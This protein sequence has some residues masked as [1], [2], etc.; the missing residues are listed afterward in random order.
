MTYKEWC[1]ELFGNPVDSDPVGLELSENFYSLQDEVSLDYIDR[2]LKDSEIHTLYWPGQIEVG[3]QIIYDNSCSDL[4]SCYVHVGDE[5]R[6]VIAISNLDLLYK[7]YFERYCSVPVKRI[8]SDS[9]FD[10]RIGYLCSMFWDIFAL[11]PGN[12]SEPMID[13]AV[14]VMRNAINSKNDNCIVS[15]I[16]GLGHWVHHTSQARDVLEE[17][18]RHPST[19]NSVIHQYAE[20]AKTGCIQ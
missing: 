16:H 14:A 9:L 18:T 4:P 19:I 10:G 3:L 15:A 2:C 12:A 6:R 5:G 8:G 1:D 7:N 20:Q 17:W 11:Y 13:A